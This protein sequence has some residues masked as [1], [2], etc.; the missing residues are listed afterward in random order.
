VTQAVARAARRAQ[1]TYAELVKGLRASPVVAPDETGWRVNGAKA[2][3]WAF[4]GARLVVYRVATGDGARG[5]D[6]AEAVLGADYAGIIERDGWAP[7]RRFTRARHQSCLAHLLRRCRNLL[8]VAD[9]GQ[10]RTPH[11]VARIP[12]QALHVRDRRGPFP[13]P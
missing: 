7:Y 13:I 8:A 4:V 12:R 6:T 3:L 11:A 2:W 10:A 9:R 5:Y 1:P